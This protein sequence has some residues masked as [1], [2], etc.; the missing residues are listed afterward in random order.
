MVISP[1]PEGI[2][3]LLR[4]AW[5]PC[6]HNGLDASYSFDCH[7][8]RKAGHWYTRSYLPLGKRLVASNVPAFA[9]LAP[10]AAFRVTSPRGTSALSCHVCLGR[11]RNGEDAE[12]WSLSMDAAQETES[13]NKGESPG[14]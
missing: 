14:K 5:T 7:L 8:I 4:P 1:V 11:H 3:N 12:C 10:S 6:S 2:E 9:G 13:Y